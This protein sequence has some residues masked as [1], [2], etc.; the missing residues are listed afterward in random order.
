MQE[1][2]GKLKAAGL[3]I[4]FISASLDVIVEAAGVY[5]GVDAAHRRGSPMELKGGL[6]TGRVESIYTLKAPVVRAWL[7]GPALLAFGDS[8]RSDFQFMAEAAGAAFM[9]NP[10]DKF[11]SKDT[12]QVGGRF[13]SVSF[14]NTVNSLAAKKLTDVP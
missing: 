6:Y 9:I 13:V 1:L 5:L 12:E 8:A 7:E 11:L 14:T 3:D 2:L 10:D 4:Y